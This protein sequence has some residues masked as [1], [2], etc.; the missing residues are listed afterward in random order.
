M[1]RSRM[2]TAHSAP[3]DNYLDT[4]P[5]CIL[6]H[7]F[8][9]SLTFSFFPPARASVLH[10]LMLQHVVNERRTQQRLR[11]TKAATLP[12][13]LRPDP[14]RVIDGVRNRAGGTVHL[15]GGVG[16]RQM[17]KHREEK[18]EIV[19]VAGKPECPLAQFFGRQSIQG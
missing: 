19:T 6:N 1:A 10:P 5:Y 4:E 3:H 17:A 14:N 18:P 2:S 11:L 12:G 8:P 7:V 13:E 15:L 9:R 16:V